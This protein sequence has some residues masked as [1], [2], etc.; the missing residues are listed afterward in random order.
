MVAGP[1]KS[2]PIK[3]PKVDGPSAMRITI[4]RLPADA[5]NPAGTWDPD[6]TSATF[7]TY[8]HLKAVFP[9][10]G[11]NYAQDASGALL[12]LTEFDPEGIEIF[13]PN[14]SQLAL[15][16]GL[17]NYGVTAEIVPMVLNGYAPR[18]RRLL[19][20]LPTRFSF[21]VPPGHGGV[22]TLDASALVTNVS[23]SGTL[24]LTSSWPFP[25]IS[26]T[27]LQNLNANPLLIFTSFQA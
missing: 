6:I 12:P 9:T 23:D 8:L 13:P 1:G 26:G 16:G 20:M 25:I 7:Q 19:R 4:I 18:T 15:V 22:G 3:I 14:C 21:T 5:S 24:L 2:T 10:S 27:V 17:G 11:A